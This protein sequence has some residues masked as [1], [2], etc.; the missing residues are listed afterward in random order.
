ML[1]LSSVLIAIT[2][3]IAG[4]AIVV[5][6]LAM[7][8]ECTYD[9]ETMT[10]L[11]RTYERGVTVAIENAERPPSEPIAFSLPQNAWVFGALGT[12][13][14]TKDGALGMLNASVTRRT[15]DGLISIKPLGWYV[16][17]VRGGNFYY[18]TTSFAGERRRR[19]D[20]TNECSTMV[21]EP[22][23]SSGTNETNIPHFACLRCTRLQLL[24]FFA[25][26]AWTK[27]AVTVKLDSLVKSY[28]GDEEKRVTLIDMINYLMDQRVL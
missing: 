16:Y 22:R 18:L 4:T 12:V 6:C 2:L 28:G 9:I 20:S 13:A 10:S 14:A 26:G 11:R 1:P 23:I 3:I 15:G 27:D 19:C 24:S 25:D 7:V 5:L 21:L 17:Y 8:R